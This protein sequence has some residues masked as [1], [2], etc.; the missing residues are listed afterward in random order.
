MTLSHPVLAQYLT[1]LVHQRGTYHSAD[2]KLFRCHQIV[3]GGDIVLT[4]WNVS[5]PEPEQAQVDAQTQAPPFLRFQQMQSDRPAWR[6]YRNRVRSEIG[7]GNPGG[8]GLADRIV[9]EVLP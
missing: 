8:I 7:D 2:P 5:F 1:Y 3:A 6:Q 9:D 4:E